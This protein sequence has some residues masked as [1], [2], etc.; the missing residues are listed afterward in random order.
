MYIITEKGFKCKPVMY[1]AKDILMFEV[2]TDYYWKVH[3][4]DK[5]EFIVSKVVK[6]QVI[7]EGK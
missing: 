7:F 6:C 4:K 2:M 3:M 1:E 5:R